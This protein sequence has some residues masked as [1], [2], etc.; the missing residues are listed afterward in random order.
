MKIR[1]ASTVSALLIVSAVASAQATDTDGW[2]YVDNSSVHI[3]H[4]GSTGSPGMA[5][6]CNDSGTM[7]ASIALESGNMFEKLSDTST[8]TREKAGTLTVGDKA[9]R[10]RWT[11]RPNSELVSPRDRKYSRRL[12]N[13]VVTGAPVSVDVSLRNPVSLKLPA[14]D[15]NFAQFAKACSLTKSAS[16]K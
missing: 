14:V 8:R 12:Y 9:E 10:I 6:V 4:T 11:Y 1:V 7:I 2:T 16:N 13:A 3:L 15:D 5:L